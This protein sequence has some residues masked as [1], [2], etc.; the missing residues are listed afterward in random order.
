[1][2]ERSSANRYSQGGG[3]TD[4]ERGGREQVRLQAVACFERGEK[5]REIAAAL[6]VSERSVER[7]RRQ[8]R[9]EG[10][11]GVASKGSPGRPRLSDT[12][13]AKLEREL[14]RGPLAHG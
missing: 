14:E 5:N 4:S 9:E 2:S 10:L 8:W 6:R 1:M 3:L 13:I 7:W 11:A 12:Q